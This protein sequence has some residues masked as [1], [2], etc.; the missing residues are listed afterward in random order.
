MAAMN[1]QGGGEGTVGGGPGGGYGGAGGFPPMKKD[2]DGNDLECTLD[3]KERQIFVSP[4][5]WM[6]PKMALLYFDE[7]NNEYYFAFNLLQNTSH[8]S[9][10]RFLSFLRHREGCGTAGSTGFPSAAT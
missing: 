6:C 9:C 2:E 10:R 5:E 3:M 8:I 4:L 1:M 7:S